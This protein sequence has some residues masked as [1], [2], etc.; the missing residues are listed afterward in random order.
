MSVTIE[1]IMD[2][3]TI[4]KGQR[5]YRFSYDSNE[6]YVVVDDGAHDEMYWDV[7]HAFVGRKGRDFA[8][9]ALPWQGM[10]ADSLTH[11]HLEDLTDAPASV[12]VYEDNAGGLNLYV[13]M[14][15]GSVAYGHH[16]YGQ[17]G[18]CAEDYRGALDGADVTVWDGNDIGDTDRE[19]DREA[20]NARTGGCSLI[21]IGEPGEAAT[22]TV[23]VDALCNAGE[24]FATALGC[25]VSV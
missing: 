14:H 19:S 20:Y 6:A 16:Y 7:Y 25:D 8:S 9:R 5:L 13:I 24:V 15:D 1:S 4:S 17:E 23:D 10:D 18:R 11:N 12:E 21:A 3:P 2:V 22:D